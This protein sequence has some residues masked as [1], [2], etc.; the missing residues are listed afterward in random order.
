M[1]RLATLLVVAMACV[2]LGTKL[3]PDPGYWVLMLRAAA[4][5]GIVGGLADWFAVTAIFRQP[6]GLPIPHTAVIP[7]NKD[8]IG[9]GLAVFVEQHFAHPRLVAAR[10]ASIEPARRLGAWLSEGR[11]ADD[12]ARRLTA[13][14]PQ[15]LSKIREDDVRLLFMRA[16]HDQLEGVELGP[17]IGRILQVLR[18]SDRHHE[19][20]DEVLRLMRRT[21]ADNAD[22]IGRAVEERSS[23]WIPASVD[24]RMATS[25]TQAL[26]ELLAALE[27]RDHDVR[28]QFDAATTR[29]IDELQTTEIHRERLE[30]I[31]SGVLGNPTVQ[32]YLA[33][34]WNEFRTMLI[35]V[36]A[37]DE[38]GLRRGLSAALRSLGRS[39]LDDPTLQATIDR[40]IEA[41]ARSVTAGWR[42]EIGAFIAEVVRGWEATTLS[43]R[44]EGSV[45]RDLQFIR[46]NGTLVGAII[47]CVLFVIV[48]LIG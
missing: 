3:V 35:N 32:S 27:D 2:F 37:H 7:R 6:M 36:A 42:K 40:R 38:S 26:G 17:I 18:D 11:N 16:L 4:E 28:R 12:V 21:L 34:L 47:G 39:I 46:I 19:F 48:N 24:R 1:R 9:A 8:R 22:R 25:L 20:F 43:D 5:A 13:V 45:G 23:W 41:A 31:R 10:V 44:I 30:E 33:S 15:L 14:L 29:L